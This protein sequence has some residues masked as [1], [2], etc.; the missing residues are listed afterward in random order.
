MYTL[1]TMSAKFVTLPL[2]VALEKRLGKLAQ[3]MHRSRSF[4]AAEAIREYVDNNEW[5]IEEIGRALQEA[6]R[7]DFA[8]VREVRK[9]MHKWTK[10]AH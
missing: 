6:D 10:S 5:Q 3:S 8:D 4:L 9:V 2:D 7:G 1:D